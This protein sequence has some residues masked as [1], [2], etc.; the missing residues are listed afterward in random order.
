MQPFDVALVLT[1][2]SELTLVTAIVGAVVA[3]AIWIRLRSEQ[4]TTLELE[5]QNGELRLVLAR[6]RRLEGILPICSHCKRVRDD[7][8]DWQSVEDYVAARSELSFSHGICP[9]CMEQHYEAP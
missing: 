4:R 1:A 7:R 5:R 3:L 6:I 9:D 2:V 8:G